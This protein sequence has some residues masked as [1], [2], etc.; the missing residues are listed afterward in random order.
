MDPYFR[1]DAIRQR[2]RVG[3]LRGHMDTFAQKLS[4]HG[5]AI[6]TGQRQLRTVSRL[7]QWM[8]RRGLQANDLDEQVLKRFLRHRRRYGCVQH[9]DPKSLALLLEHLREGGIADQRTPSVADDA[10]GQ[11]ERD[12]EQYL[13]RERGLVATTIANYLRVARTFLT[14]HFDKETIELDRLR[15]LDVI[16]FVR[17]VAHQRPPSTA[18]NMVTGLRVFVRFL[19]V[20]GRTTVDLTSSVS[21]IPHRK[22]ATLP[23][24][25]KTNEVESLLRSCDQM[26]AIGKRDYAVLCLLARLGLRAG[27]VVAMTLDDIDWH[28]GELTIR[29]KGKTRE[30]LPLLEEVGQAL[31]SYLRE[32]RPSCATRRLFVARGHLTTGLRDRRPCAG[33]WTK[34]SGDPG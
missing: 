12:F 14:A 26:T 13:L 5:Y 22:L 28:A 8:G 4:E 34:R 15:P 23:L 1:Y 9:T 24:S 7:S 16:R 33:S 19:Y 30:R 31:V 6:D 32:A 2:L 17:R 3:P 18:K 21:T 25:L 11:V 27:E 29:G 20:Q 10:L